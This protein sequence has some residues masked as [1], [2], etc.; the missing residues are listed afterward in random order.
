MP[1]PLEPKPPEFLQKLKWLVLYG[2]RYKRYVLAGV[3]AFVL[4]ATAG[5]LWDKWWKGAG[6]STDPPP[7]SLQEATYS[8]KVQAGRVGWQSSGFELKEHDT[9]VISA[10]GEWSVIR[11]SDSGGNGIP[12]GSSFAMPSANEGCLIERTGDKEE[13][14]QVFTSNKDPI[15]LSKPGPI[16]F[17]VNGDRNPPREAYHGLLIVKITIRTRNP[18][19]YPQC[20]DSSTCWKVIPSTI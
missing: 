5:M 11:T 8:F 9:A 18:A 13:D 10:T 12:A 2:P 15:H 17:L 19:N 6:G 7:P 20:D 14:T 4:M 3:I 16:K 1:D